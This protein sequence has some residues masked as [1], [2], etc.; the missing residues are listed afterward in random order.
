M[1][2][3]AAN[4]NSHGTTADFID[5]LS[6]FSRLHRAQRWEGTFG[7]FLSN[8]LPGHAVALARTSHEYIWDMLRWHGRAAQPDASENVRARE[9]FRRELFGIDEP[10]S[11]VVDYFKAAAAGSDVGR[12]RAAA[13]GSALRRQV[14]ARDPAEARTRGIQPHRRGGAV[15]HPR[16]AA[17]REPPEPH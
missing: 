8:I 7:E 11:R 15:R 3:L 12:R 6:S 4:Q 9:L 2:P 17:A 10:L 1:R 16:L 5:T 14:D 13:A